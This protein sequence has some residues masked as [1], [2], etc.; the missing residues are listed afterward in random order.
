MGKSLG[1][2]KYPGP[3][4]RELAQLMP[5]M[6]Q[7]RFKR[8]RQSRKTRATAYYDKLRDRVKWE[9]ADAISKKQKGKINNRQFKYRMRA[10]VRDAMK[11]MFEVGLWTSGV[12]GQVSPK[13]FTSA[14]EKRWIDSAVRQE[15]KFVD[16][17]ADDVIRNKLRMP[18]EKRVGM[19]IDTL[20]GM[21]TSAKVLASKANSVIWWVTRKDGRVCK[22]CKFLESNSPY[23]KFTLAASPPD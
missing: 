19:Y 13:R 20:H 16:R 8:L 3:E 11:E 10:A 21:L 23:T 22:S 2:L 9:M 1:D 7:D 6:S 17:F 14:A 18:V 4:A 12:E 5:Q 15:M